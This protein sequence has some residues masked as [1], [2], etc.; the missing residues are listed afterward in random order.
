MKRALLLAALV[1]TL[2]ALGLFQIAEPS[3]IQKL[4]PHFPHNEENEPAYY[5]DMIGY[6]FHEGIWVALLIIATLYFTWYGKLLEKIHALE[7]KLLTKVKVSMVWLV[8]I[9][10]A[11]TTLVATVGMEQFPNSA[12][13]YAYL[14]QA[15]Q[16]SQ[17]K[18]WDEVHPEPEFF[19]FHHLA[20]KDGKWVGR[21]PPGWPL[22]LSIAF[23]LGIPTFLVNAV[24]GVAAMLMTFKFVRR[25]YDER[26]ALWAT[27][28]LAF[29]SF[30]IFNA[31]TYFSHMVSMLVGLLF[32]YLSYRYLQTKKILYVLGAGFFLGL[33]VMTRQLTA[34]I[35]L[36]PIGV[37]F[38]YQLK[39][40]SFLPLV[41]M[42]VGAIPGVAFFLWYNYTITGNALVPVTMWTNAD[43]AL[44]FVKGHTPVKG[45]KFTFKRLAMFLYWA[46]PSFLILYLVYLF[47][48]ARDYKKILVHPEDY[49]FLLLIIGYFFYYHSGG[50][51]YGPRFYLEGLP[52]LII[53]I[54]LKALRTNQRWAKVFFFL[55]IAF[56]LVRIPFIAYRE[57]RVVEER[58]D[59]YT[60][61]E[62]QGLGNAVV[63][64]SSQTGVI[65]SM[66]VEN[67][68]RNDH[69]YNN[70]VIY[71]R[72]LG[73]KNRELME[74][75]KGKE[76][77]VYKREIN[78]VEGTLT[79]VEDFDPDFTNP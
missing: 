72:D 49:L 44:G 71:A 12:D 46:S 9:F 53:L 48:R 57:H 32:V 10:F 77:Y 58:K 55:G 45:A 67:L 69:Y 1:I 29:S 52:F 38:L 17:G 65:R 39:L 68:N 33:L 3:I 25:I 54:T 13:E 56:N 31:A 18:L 79:K 2:I 24:I 76:F 28:A 35:F 60:Q 6:L 40:R 27:V 62:K 59:V 20:Q 7:E 78:K 70:E 73:E 34:L 14:F 22:M 16:L 50:N 51:Q 42:G 5:A 21:F 15:E 63:F 61:V 64:I 47:K 37:Y 26:V 4:S 66:P 36:L 19:E 41:M 8:V 43:E 74:H 30:F 75:Y 23:V 11:I